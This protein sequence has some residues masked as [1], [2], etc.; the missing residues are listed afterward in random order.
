MLTGRR[1]SQGTVPYWQAYD[2]LVVRR[3]PSRL[4]PRQN[5]NIGAFIIRIRFLGAHYTTIIIRNP[6]NSI[7]N[8]FKAPIPPIGSLG[9][10]V[11]NHGTAKFESSDIFPDLRRYSE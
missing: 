11:S 9:K 4:N 8:F 5:P 3:N 7:G 1:A 10:D 2:R 6:Q